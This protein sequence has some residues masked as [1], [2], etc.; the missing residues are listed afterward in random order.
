MV[1]VVFFFPVM[2]MPKTFVQVLYYVNAENT[3]KSR[4]F[5]MNLSLPLM[6]QYPVKSSKIKSL[7]MDVTISKY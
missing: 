4:T 7:L 5:L 1:V 6:K 2:S 3:K